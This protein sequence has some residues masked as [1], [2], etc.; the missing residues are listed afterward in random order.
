MSELNFSCNYMDFKHQYL[1]GNKRFC[2]SKIHAPRDRKGMDTFA[3]HVI[4]LTYG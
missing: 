3:L 4:L 1:P 2:G